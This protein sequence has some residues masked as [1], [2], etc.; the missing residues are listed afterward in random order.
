[1]CFYNSK[2]RMYEVPDSQR[3][4]EEKMLTPP[5]SA[6]VSLNQ[7]KVDGCWSQR[8]PEAFNHFHVKI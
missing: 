2:L 6:Q 3:A 8:L 5:P 1:M 4:K 7:L